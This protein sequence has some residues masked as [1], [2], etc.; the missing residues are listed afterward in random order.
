MCGCHPPALP[1]PQKLLKNGGRRGGGERELNRIFK[2]ALRK[3]P[4][5]RNVLNFPEI[6][7]II[8]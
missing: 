5:L 2:N 1:V 7:P 8:S 3:K 4:P 6:A